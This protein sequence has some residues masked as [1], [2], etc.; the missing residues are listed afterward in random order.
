MLSL[1]RSITIDGVSVFRDHA[2]PS[3]FWYL[4]GPVDLARRGADQSAAF[5]FLKYKAAVAGAGVKGGGFLTFESTL[6]L[7]RGVETRLAG[8]LASEP[9]AIPP[10]RLAAATFEE[11]TVQCIALNMQGAGGTAA[12]APPPGAFN[13]VERIL[14]A[15]VPS[16]D[17]DNKAAF[18]LTL[19][20]EGATILEQAFEN[21]MTPIGVIYDLKY[22]AMRPA[23]NVEITADFERIFNHFSASLEGQYKFFRVSLEAAFESLVQSGA[24]TIK[25][26][27]FTGE[28]DEREQEKWALDFF[29]EDLLTKWFEPTLQPGQLAAQQAT[30]TPLSEVIAAGRDILRGPTGGNQP[31]M[32]GQAGQPA[33]PTTPGGS[34]QATEQI[35]RA[36]LVP[37]L[38]EPSPLTDGRGVTHT[39]AAQGLAERLTVTGAGAVVR[40]AGQPVT[41]DAQGRISVTVNPNS[42]VGIVVEWPAAAQEQVF[43][44]FF[45][46]DKPAEAGWRANPPSPEFRAY[47]ENSTSDPRFRDASGTLRIEGDGIW[48]GLERGADRL[49]AWIQAQPPPRTVRLDAYASHE[50]VSTANETQRRDHNLRLSQRRLDVASAI[51]LRAGGSVASGQ[52]AHGDSPAATRP[53]AHSAMGGDPDNRVVH[54]TGRA[55]DGQTSRWRGRLRRPAN[56]RVEPPA[57]PPT[58]PKPPSTPGTP[59]STPAA[60]GDNSIPVVA[61]LKL[62]FIRQE[63]RKTLTLRYNRA[64]AVRRSYAPQG[65]FGL[66]LKDLGNKSKYFREIDLDDPFFREFTVEASI[67]IDFAPIGL[68]SAQL[69]IDYGD[70]A[71]PQDHKHGDFV[72]T[73]QDTGP[74]TFKAFLNSTRDIDYDVSY[75]YHFDP[76]SDWTGDRF[77][78]EIPKASTEDRTLF[79]NPYEQIEFRE[80]AFS[81]GEIEWEILESVEVRLE[82][83]GYGDPAPRKSFLLT[84]DSGAQSWKLRGAK[85]APADRLVTYTLVHTQKNGRSET[86]GPF[87]ATV[88]AIVVHDLFEESLRL[89]FIPLFDAA[90]TERVFIDVEYRDPPNNYERTERLELTGAGRDPAKLRIPLRGEQRSY[91]R[92]FT[93]VGKNGAFDQRAWEDSTEELVPVR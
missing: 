39:P 37:D 91:R 78:Y 25:V 82:A 77:S 48:T 22:L 24:I 74:K 70:P 6:R 44:L 46:F 87:V 15:S 40:I 61:A 54:V 19:S 65:F 5:T 63:E 10:V 16:L 26:L 13:A 64:E 60:G 49:R 7:P 27:N 90:Q 45:D 69:A 18:S 51:V 47:V 50:H 29:R 35:Q 28:E 21:G 89:E 57:T 92:R 59:P 79:V 38:Q 73:S 76:Q 30:A 11:G 86:Q 32:S 55:V 36:E 58:T 75:Q 1:D 23:I 93:F 34:G 67:P 20:A 85:P 12:T 9:G 42:E 81:P 17:A 41:P 14:G 8:R 33:T 3:Q 71:V 4:P 56:L 53:G 2:D 72:F 66:L 83:P 62:K 68:S 84:K 31:G 43:G 80:I 88:N 52:S